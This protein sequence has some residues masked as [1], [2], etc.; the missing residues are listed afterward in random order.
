MALSAADANILNNRFLAI[1]RAIN[2]LNTAV[3]KLPTKAQMIALLNIRQTEID[4]LTL[5]VTTLE[6]KV[7]VLE[8]AP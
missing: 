5:R 7:D 3:N 6:S 2:D 8:T 1:E 4:D